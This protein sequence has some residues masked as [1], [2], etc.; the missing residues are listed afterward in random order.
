MILVVFGKDV[1]TRSRSVPVGLNFASLQ[2]LWVTHRV[3]NRGMKSSRVI[4]DRLHKKLGS[5]DIVISQT[6]VP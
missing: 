6:L 4:S 5:I 2:G 1:E 3:S